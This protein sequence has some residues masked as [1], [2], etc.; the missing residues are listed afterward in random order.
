MHTKKSYYKPVHVLYSLLMLLA[1]SWLTVCLP[2]VNESQE[3]AKELTEQGSAS[4]SDDNSNPLS[5]TNEEK[6]ERGANTLSEYLHDMA[7]MEHH[8]I[9]VNTFYKCHPSDL[10]FD[11]HPQLVS[12]PPKA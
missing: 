8:F 12:P 4:D 5:N 2:Y 9:I 3:I 10:Y 7:I 11:F 6:T 1:L